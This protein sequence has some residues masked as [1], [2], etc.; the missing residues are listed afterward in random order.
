MNTTIIGFIRVNQIGIQTLIREIVNWCMTQPNIYN[1]VNTLLYQQQLQSRYEEVFLAA[2]ML[3]VEFT[4]N[5]GEDYQSGQ[6][7]GDFIHGIMAANSMADLNKVFVILQVANE[8]ADMSLEYRAENEITPV[9]IQD[10]MP[11]NLLECPICYNDYSYID[12]LRTECRHEF[13]K[14]CLFRCIETKVVD[15]KVCC[16]LCRDEINKVYT[17]SAE[18]MDDL[19]LKNEDELLN[20]EITEMMYADRDYTEY[21]DTDSVS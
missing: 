2:T 5:Y 8:F 19:N 3:M 9:F 16:P 10:T 1:S 6:W 14:T 11:E 18:N 13:C 21:N 12:I 20:F 4:I 15:K 17:Y 7:F